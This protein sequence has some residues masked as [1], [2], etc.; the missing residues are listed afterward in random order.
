VLTLYKI[1]MF[2]TTLEIPQSWFSSGMTSFTIV[3]PVSSSVW[4]QQG[5]SCVHKPCC[6]PVLRSVRTSQDVSGLASRRFPKTRMDMQT[7]GHM[8]LCLLGAIAQV[9]PADMPACARSIAAQKSLLVAA[10]FVTDLQSAS[11]ALSVVCFW[12]WRRFTG[13]VKNEII[14]QTWTPL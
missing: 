8:L 2:M 1:T 7:P 10:N 13:R 14:A 6:C 11:L 5:T 9:F 3:L 12:C 4:H